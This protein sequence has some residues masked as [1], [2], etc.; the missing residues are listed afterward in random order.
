MRDFVKRDAAD[1]ELNSSEHRPLTGAGGF[2]QGEFESV[3]AEEVAA[4]LSALPATDRELMLSERRTALITGAGGLLGREM[5]TRLDASGWQVTALPHA[6]LDITSETDVLRTVEAVYPDVLINCAAT[7]DVDRCETD[8]GWAYLVNETGP[9]ILARACREF[10]VEI[11]HVSTDYV[12]DGSKE[13]FYTQEDEPRPLSVYGQSKLAGEVAV[14][15]E[16]SRAYI[17]RTSWLFGRGGKNFGSRVIEYARQGLKIKGVTDQVSIPSYARDVSARIEDILALGIHGLY[18][19]TSS[20]P[21]TWYEF[22]RAAL[23]LAGLRSTE[24]EPVSRADLNQR[25][26][27]PHSTPM[28]CLL[29]EQLGLEPLRHW[30]EALVEFVAEY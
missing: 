30:R 9:R 26:P 19:A 29:S 4:E 14:R 21:T 2:R 23:D 25:A 10:G 18:H 13:G 6:K 17:V 16:S 5:S 1:P 24:I 3:V 8:A 28:R 12:F 27:R 15:D 20:G 11:V 7:A 22:A